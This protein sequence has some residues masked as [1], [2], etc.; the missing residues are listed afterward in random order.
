MTPTRGLFIALAA[1]LPM[2]AQ[3]AALHLDAGLSSSLDRNWKNERDTTGGTGVVTKFPL[4]LEGALVFPIK[5]G[6]IR[7]ALRFAVDEPFSNFQLGGDWIHTFS[8]KGAE[9]LYGTAGLSLNFVSGRI[10]VVPPNYP[11]PGTYE[12][13]S[14]SARPGAR[15]GMGYAFSRA[16]AFEGA[17][18]FISLGSTGPNGFLHSSSIYMS[19]TGSYRIPKV[20]GSM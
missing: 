2:Q 15:L 3:E 10:Q 17:M 4:A 8:R 7:T 1:V 14:Q 16:F 9:T 18:H 6:A 11:T 12:Q 5:S 13:R 19:L 20:F